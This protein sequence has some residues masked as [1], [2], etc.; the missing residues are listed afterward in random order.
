M[1]DILIVEDNK[2]LCGLLCDFLRMENYTVS[3]AETGEK[4]LSLYEKYGAR[5]VL[6]DIN[7]PELDGFAVCGKIRQNDNTPI[8]MLTARTDKEDKLNGILAGADDYIEKPYDIDILIAKIK[9]IFKRRLALDVISEGD[10]SLNIANETVTKRGVPVDVAS[11]EFEILRL[12]IE[13]KGQTL[14]KEFLFNRVW[15]ADS[16]SELQTLTVHIKWLRQKIEDDPK[17]PSK[18]ITVWGRG[19]RWGN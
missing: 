10:I 11:K 5:L 14:N 8:I 17:N 18:I 15:G 9:G 2:E 4:A 12:L 19:Y 1:I 3:I 13:N 16:E 6:L 7:L